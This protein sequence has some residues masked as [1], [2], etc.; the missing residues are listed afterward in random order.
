MPQLRCALPKRGAALV[1]LKRILRDIRALK[2]LQTLLAA[3]GHQ[4][5]SHPVPGLGGLRS[6]TEAMVVGQA[7]SFP[8][9][10]LDSGQPE[11][12]ARSMARRL[13]SRGRSAGVIALDA[14]ARRIALSVA[15]DG[16]PVLAVS[17]DSPGSLALVSLGRLAGAGEGGTL[18]YAARV[19][20]AL[21]VEEAGARF[22]RDFRATLER[23]TAEL[24]AD[25]PAG[26][27]RGFVLLQLTRVLFLYFVQAKGWLGGRERFL[28]EEVDRCLA[29]KG[30]IH[31]HLLRPLFFGT[32]NRPLPDR[33]HAAARFGAIPF[34]NGGLFEPHPIERAMRCG[35]SNA[36]WQEAFD[37][38][39]ERFQFTVR[40]GAGGGDIAPDMLGRV[41]EGVMAPESRRASGTFYTPAALVRQILDAALLAS[42][43]GAAP[44][45]S[46]LDTLTI[47][48]PAVG[49]GAFL[50]GALERLAA[51][52]G[53]RSEDESARR[54][55]VLQRNLFGVDRSATAVRLAELRLWL[56]VIAEDH[57]ER[58]S[59]VQPLPNLDC[60]VRQ[61]DSLF[62]PVG[63]RARLDATAARLAGRIAEA[64]HGVVAAV[65]QPKRTLMRELRE[66][67]G[68][69]AALSLASA[70]RHIDAQIGECLG[71][72][73]ERDLFGERR[74]LDSVLRARVSTLRAERRAVR[75]ARRTLARERELPWFHYESQFADVFAAG[76]FDIVVGNP[77]WL[78]AE[79]IPPE[80]RRRLSERYRWWRGG[81][82]FGNHPDLSVAFLERALEL[83]A[84]GGVVA[85][86]LPAKVAT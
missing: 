73:R 31:R 36:A 75:H 38:L 15:F 27:R 5:L 74:G 35:I 45:P 40:E 54:R 46:A 58:P 61:G 62:D 86:L 65:G 81:G 76:G 17:L 11:R 51:L 55:R 83:A 6:A 39:F 33:G 50:L 22:F 47:L 85:L 72:A 80:Q 23:M 1:E 77:P 41:F 64:R 84:P 60:L 8:W 21:S 44:T 68:R 49:S 57:T 71:A 78:R 9:F 18:A 2:D 37:C 19:A 30:G 34:L 13:A 70:E 7:G 16:T 14:G 66:L 69:A 42:R 10:A 4:P 26:S 63:C 28:A 25:R 67:E 43:A 53:K 24:P 52:G 56:A 32:L 20:E 48:D 29:A 79:Q 3:L 12:A 59:R 82:A